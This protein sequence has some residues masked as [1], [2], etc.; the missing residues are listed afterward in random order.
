MMPNSITIA[1]DTP[2]P[3]AHKLMTERKIRRLPV[4]DHGDL[5]G[6]PT[7]SDILRIVVE[8]WQKEA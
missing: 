7:E 4:L 6:S 8:A 2:L 5:V 1:G 3:G